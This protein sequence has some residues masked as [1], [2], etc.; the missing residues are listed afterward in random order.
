MARSG[1]TH[2]DHMA[3]LGGTIMIRGCGMI[4]WHDQRTH[5]ML[6][7]GQS[8]SGDTW[9]GQGTH[10]MHRGH[11]ACSGD[12]WHARGTVKISMV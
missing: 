1:D 10:G 11:M 3:C 6:R 2:R 9:H 8:G 7:G 4:T 12:T 5:V